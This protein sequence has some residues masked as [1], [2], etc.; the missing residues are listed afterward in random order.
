MTVAAMSQKMPE[1]V[2]RQVRGEQRVSEPPTTPT[3][4]R[5]QIRP[6]AGHEQQAGQEGVAQG[7]KRIGAGT[8]AQ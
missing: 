3:I 5:A 6:R 2:A 7:V 8:S 1:G 4:L